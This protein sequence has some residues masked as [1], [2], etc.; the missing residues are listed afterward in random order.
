MDF[1]DDMRMTV[2]QAVD[3]SYGFHASSKNI[4]DNT[5]RA[6]Q[7]LS[8]NA[9]I[10]R[11]RPDVSAFGAFFYLDVHRNTILT[12]TSNTHINTPSSKKLSIYYGSR[13][14]TMMA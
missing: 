14:K 4:R 9:F 5:A 8:N 13:T 7:L 12:K 3:T 1:L 6:T 2:R 11:V 10:Y